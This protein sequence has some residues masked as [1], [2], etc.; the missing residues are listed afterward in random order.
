MPDLNGNASPVKDP[1]FNSLLVGSLTN[2]IAEASSL[3]RPFTSLIQKHGT[4]ADVDVSS[5]RFR[6]RTTDAGMQ[7]LQMNSPTP[8]EYYLEKAE[9]NAEALR[10]V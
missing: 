9:A 1:G 4:L 7:H 10:Y 5:E 2:R 3:P 6:A 8:V